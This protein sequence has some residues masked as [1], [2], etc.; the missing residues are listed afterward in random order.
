MLGTGH[1]R[2]DLR[3]GK[4]VNRGGGSRH[5]RDS[6]QRPKQGTQGGSA[7][8]ARKLPTAALRSMSVTTLGLHI[9]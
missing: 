6:Q 4:M 8:V 9:S 7:G 1:A 3:I 2:I 5:Q